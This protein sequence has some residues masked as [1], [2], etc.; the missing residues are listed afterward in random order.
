[1]YR[2]I[3]NLV[4]HSV[5]LTVVDLVW[6]VRTEFVPILLLLMT[7]RGWANQWMEGTECSRDISIHVVIHLHLVL[8]GLRFRAFIIQA[9]WFGK[10]PFYYFYSV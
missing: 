6:S 4:S 2:V 5:W 8:F 3:H 7:G 1:V 9:V 10:E